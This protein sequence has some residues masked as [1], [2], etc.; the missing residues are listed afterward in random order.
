M[1]FAEKQKQKNDQRGPKKQKISNK[2]IFWG[3]RGEGLVVPKRLFVCVFVF[4]MFVFVFS[5]PGDFV[6]FSNLFCCLA[7]KKKQIQKQDN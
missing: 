6:F 5:S 7:E 2:V 1:F 4:F 3:L